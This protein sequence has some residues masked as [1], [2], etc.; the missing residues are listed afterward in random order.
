[1]RE[2]G[3]FSPG[4]DMAA[5]KR[6]LAQENY[7]FSLF[8]GEPLLMP[9]ADLEE[10]FRWGLERFGGNAIQTNGSLITEEHLALFARYGV[11]VGISMDGPD[12]LNDVREAGTLDKT[13][14]LTAQSEWAIRRLCE[15]RQ[16]PSLI[17]TLHRGNAVGARLDRLKQWIAE[18][19]TLGV[20]HM[21]L[22]LLEVESPEVRRRWALT[23]DEN[24]AAFL[25]LHAFQQGFPAL[26]FDVFSDLE[27][28]LLARDTSQGTTCIWN[29]CDPYTT[30]AVRGVNGV[31]ENINCGRTNKDGVDWNKAD[32]EGFERQLVLYDTPQSENGCQGC[33]FFIACKGQ[34][35]GTAVD[36][37]WRNRTEHCGVWM[38]LLERTEQELF[39]RGLTPI[40]RSPE[41]ER[42][43]VTML[44]AWGEGRNLSIEQA[45]AVL[46]GRPIP[47]TTTGDHIDHWDAPDGYQHSDAGI[48]LHGDAGTTVMH[49]DIPHGD[50]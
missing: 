6:A 12:E 23:E 17:V 2:A 41:L 42:I 45:V 48:D 46:H 14:A 16:P 32:V 47:G 20:R 27:R 11:S 36:G 4:Y 18:L 31:G 19:Y 25:E 29:A 13:R 39:A 43:E 26:Q 35:P 28:L 49:G 15:R 10:M 24:V 21:R 30:R 44:E 33:R 37:D 34:C 38:R 5:M 50:A 40:T 3:N 8:C 9:F 22:H 7:R 1:M